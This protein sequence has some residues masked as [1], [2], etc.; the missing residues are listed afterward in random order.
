M[1]H[2]LNL[3]RR[4]FLKSS[5]VAA[6]TFLLATKVGAVGKAWAQG[7]ESF[8][9]NVFMKLAPDGTL[10][11]MAHRSDMGQGIRTGLAQLMAEELE[12][13][14]SR[15]VVEQAEGDIKYGDQYT[16]GSRSIVKNFDRLREFAAAARFML[17]QA[18]AA[19][20][21]V[22]VGEVKAENHAVHHAA[23]GRSIGYGD[24]AAAAAT[25]AVP[26]AETVKLKDRK[27]WKFI[28]KPVPNVDLY[29]VTHG[30]AIYG[31][32]VK[33]PG[34]KYASIQRPPVLLGRVKS[35]DATKTLAFPGVE[36]VVEMPPIA[37]DQPVAFKLLGGLAVIASNTWAANEG[38]KLLE[39]EWDDG[40]NGS[41]DSVNYREMLQQ[42][43]REPGDLR[44]GHGDVTAAFTPD[45]KVVE[46]EYWS[47]HFVH[48]PM[49][50]PA[51]AANVTGDK[52]EI[53]ACCQDG[54]ALR[55]SA[56]EAIGMDEAN[57]TA[58]VTLLGG[59]FGRK[60]KPDFGAEA[61]F[62]SKTIGAPVKV[63]WMREDDVQNGYYHAAAAQFVRAAVDD[64]GRPVG[65]HHRTVFP[66][67][68]S[69]FTGQTKPGS[70][71]LDFGLTDLPYDIPNLA[72][73]SGE[74]PVHVRI[75]WKRSVQNIF[76]AFAI[77]SFTNELAVAAGRDHLEYVKDLIGPDRQIDLTHDGVRITSTTTTTSQ[78]PDRHG[79]A[80]ERARHRRHPGRLGQG[81][82]GPHRHGACRA[83]ELPDLCR[84]RHRGG[85]RGRRHGDDPP[86][87]DGG[88][89]RHGRQS[90]PREGADGGRLHLRHERR[91]LRRDH[92]QERPRPAAQFRRLPRG[93]HGHV[94]E[95][96]RGHA[97]GKRCASGRRRRARRAALRAGTL[98][99]HLRRDGQARPLAPDRPA[100]SDLSRSHPI[101]RE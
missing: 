87:R 70:W 60:S 41:Y 78:I 34:M 43:S 80:E 81:D 97:G 83:P 76:H 63:T 35:Y 22:D 69:I 23:T 84:D 30:K 99:R 64:K 48:A 29:D 14:W 28:G 18:A 72:I 6:G 57:V 16:D 51:A 21:G 45:A 19:E 61:A 82:A 46:A 56:A 94:A 53:W 1:T 26:L 49:E 2:I 79:P 52:M 44:R 9:P 85:G 96:D 31:I 39:I 95:I 58:R 67:I 3:S 50:V 65:W 11:L 101:G 38:R 17:E 77:N 4:D 54:Q 91:L 62:L 12:A 47:P 20:W 25:L 7:A 75:G 33:L 88:R 55:K 10:T 27:H 59:A 90:G 13:D 71:E 98:Q 93:P 86:R 73:E 5:A 100:R 32:D 66:A 24:L 68:M 37:A 36:Q 74:A 40:V 89:L 8:A 92:G 42:K 15:V